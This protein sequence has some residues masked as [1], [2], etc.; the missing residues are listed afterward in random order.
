MNVVSITY[1]AGRVARRCILLGASA[2]L[3]AACSKP[4]QPRSFDFFLTDSI[5]RDGTIARCERDPATAQGDIECA[6]AQRA[7]VTVQLRE[8]RE[9][10]EALER[11]S[12]AR[13]EALRRQFEAE[14][15]ARAEAAA[16]A[17][18]EAERRLLEDV[19]PR[20]TTAEP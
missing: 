12:A 6:N 19:P 20:E 2:A 9:R 8:E 13:I 3:L 18:A 11:D 4:A 15:R 16:N 1:A 7:A 5:A 17:A 14:S 10:R